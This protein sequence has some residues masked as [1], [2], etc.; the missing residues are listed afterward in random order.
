VQGTGARVILTD[1]FQ[2]AALAG[3]NNKLS[4]SQHGGASISAAPG[5]PG[6]SGN[7]IEITGGKNKIDLVPPVI[8][9]HFN[10]P[11]DISIVGFTPGS[12]RLN[13][14]GIAGIQPVLKTRLAGQT[15]PSTAQVIEAKLTPIPVRLLTATRAAPVDGRS[16]DFT[17]EAIVLN[18]GS[19]GDGSPEAV[20][21][22]LNA[23]YHAA[24]K[25]GDAAGASPADAA[26]ESLVIIGDSPAGAVIY[27]CG[28]FKILK[29]GDQ[30][31]AIPYGLG[32]NQDDQNI[33]PASLHHLVTLNGVSADRLTGHDFE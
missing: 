30:A 9:D 29:F 4:G 19:A 25:T 27:Q 18:V 14:P 13:L 7:I 16:L 31:R 17:H 20:A 6:I 10:L 33:S 1:V 11:S 3:S 26:G 32:L 15:A 23:V 28:V 5:M 8:G 21:D 22:A 2:I 24:G 12:D